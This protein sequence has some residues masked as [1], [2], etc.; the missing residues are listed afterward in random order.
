M[1]GKGR[2]NERDGRNGV[3]EKRGRKIGSGEMGREIKTE[4]EERRVVEK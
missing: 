3:R 2:D 1:W 4:R